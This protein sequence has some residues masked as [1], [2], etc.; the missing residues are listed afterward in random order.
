MRAIQG[1]IN[2]SKIDAEAQTVVLKC[3]LPPETN[4]GFLEKRLV[5]G[6][7]RQCTYSFLYHIARKPL[8]TA[9]A[10]RLDGDVE[11]MLNQCGFDEV[12]ALLGRRT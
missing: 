9:R 6:L 10:Y 2:F 7:G 3:H 11:S 1:Q 5:P 8:K 4:E 12:P